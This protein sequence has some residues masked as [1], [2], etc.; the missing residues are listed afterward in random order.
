M[1]ENGFDNPEDKEASGKLSEAEKKR[2]AEFENLSEK[3]VAEGY[4]RHDLTIS[5]IKAN[6]FAV[7][8]LIPL[9]IVG[10]GLFYYN[11]HGLGKGFSPW[12]I[13]ILFLF[14]LVLIVVHE[15]IHGIS[16]AIFAEHHWKDIDFGIMR[17][18][19]TPYCTCKSPLTKGQ[20]IFGGLMPLLL[21]GVVPMI[22][23]IVSGVLSV[24]FGGIIMADAAAGDIMIVWEILRYR[25]TADKIIYMDHPTQAGG[26]V[27]EK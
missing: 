15:L 20:Y 12:E 17:Q 14:L 11:H 8:L 7:V 13:I 18:Y 9:F 21:L 19:L 6:V 4:E 24:L 26:V 3:L 2:L 10:I 1:K 22:V 16:W 25:S 27:F 5:I 23:G